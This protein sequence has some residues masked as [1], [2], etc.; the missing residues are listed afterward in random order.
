M[1]SEAR[2]LPLFLPLLHPSPP[3]SFFHPSLSHPFLFSFALPSLP[4]LQPFPLPFPSP[5]LR[6]GSV[7]ECLSSPSGRGRARPLNTIGAFV[8]KLSAFMDCYLPRPH[9]ALILW[10]F[11]HQ[12]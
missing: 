5:L 9:H 11:G 2:T 7:G 6:L 12:D 8:V 4:L 10:A 3:L 1:G